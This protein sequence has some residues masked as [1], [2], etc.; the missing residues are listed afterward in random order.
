[1]LGTP[2]A[3]LR[4]PVIQVHRVKPR[5]GSLNGWIG[6]TGMY[7]SQCSQRCSSVHRMEKRRCPLRKPL[8]TEL[9]AISDAPSLHP[10]NILCTDIRFPD[11]GTKVK[12]D[13]CESPKTF[14]CHIV[15][16]VYRNTASIRPNIYLKK[17]NPQAPLLLGISGHLTPSPVG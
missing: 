11:F 4:F 15:E 6:R 13:E 14:P 9:G 5:L 3:L 2:W 17:G 12:N 8:R 10:C 1:M 7:S 16:S